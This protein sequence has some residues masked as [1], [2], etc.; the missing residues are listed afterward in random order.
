MCD[1]LNVC[2]NTPQLREVGGERMRSKI[3]FFLNGESNLYLFEL[4]CLANLNPDLSLMC[5]LNYI[6]HNK[7]ARM[8]YVKFCDIINVSA[9]YVLFFSIVLQH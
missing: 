6:Y 5:I 2:H 3:S 7:F 1:A 9:R 4:S 8:I